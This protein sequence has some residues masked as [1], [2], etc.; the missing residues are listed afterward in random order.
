M[1]QAVAARPK[2][3]QIDFVTLKQVRDHSAWYI[4]TNDG[5][6]STPKDVHDVV[7]QVFDLSNDANESFGI[8]ALDTKNK[9]NGL[10]ILSQGSLNSSVVHPREVFKRA[11]LYNAA[12]IVCFHNHPSGNPTPS[13]E[14]IILTNRLKESG[15]LLGIDVLDHIIIGDRL[16]TSMKELGVV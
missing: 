5:I 11:I 2:L 3:T 4:F 13:P 12:S 8:V 6:I 1:M 15:E 10:C 16:W 7:N 14:D 9:M